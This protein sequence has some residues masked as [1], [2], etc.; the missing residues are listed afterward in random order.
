MVVSRMNYIETDAHIIVIN[1]NNTE[2][3]S[4]WASNQLQAYLNSIN[5]LTF[6]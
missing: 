4:I 2:T 1:K 5:I 6:T 3:Q